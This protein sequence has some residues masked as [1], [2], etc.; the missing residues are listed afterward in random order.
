MN[1]LCENCKKQGVRW[2]SPSEG[3][4]WGEFGGKKVHT[5]KACE[6]KRSEAM[7]DAWWM[8]DNKL[9]DRQS[10]VEEKTKE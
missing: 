8:N 5:C 6:E 7:K 3:I 2:A 1:A 9:E 10:Q 4:V